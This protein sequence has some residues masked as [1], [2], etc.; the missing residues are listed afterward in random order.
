VNGVVALTF[1]T[2][3]GT[4]SDYFGGVTGIYKIITFPDGY[5]LVGNYGC[6]TDQINGL[7]FILAKTI[8]AH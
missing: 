7:A 8:Y 3:K 4:K 6:Y 1:V 5:R 2:N